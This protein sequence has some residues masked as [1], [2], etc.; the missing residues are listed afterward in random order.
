TAGRP[1]P[2]SPPRPSRLTS[3][4]DASQPHHA[5]D[6][7]LR[8]FPHNPR[9]HQPERGELALPLPVGLVRDA[10]GVVTKTPDREVQARI[11]LVFEIFLQRRTDVRVVRTLHE[12]GLALPRR[13]RDGQTCWRRPTLPAVTTMVKNPAY[14]GAFVY[15]RTQMGPRRRGDGRT[16]HKRR[17]LEEWKIVVKDKYPAFIDWKTFER[18]QTML[19]DNRA[20]YLLNKTRR[21]PRDGAALLHGIAWCGECGH[22]M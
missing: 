5:G 11:A 15:G 18:I 7:P 1:W 9:R 4:P 3:L 10:S 21:T 12:R 19:R 13:D 22:K 2:R 20:E 14:A 17:S 16:K 6:D 8:P